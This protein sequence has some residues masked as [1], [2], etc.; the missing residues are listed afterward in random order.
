MRKI[1]CVLVLFKKNNHAHC[2]TELSRPCYTRHFFQSTFSRN[3]RDIGKTGLYFCLEMRR[4]FLQYWRYC[5]EKDNLILLR[6]V[7]WALN[8]KKVARHWVI[9][10]AIVSCNKTLRQIERVKGHLDRLNTDWMS[11]VSQHLWEKS[12]KIYFNKLKRMITK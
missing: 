4:I 5:C 2:K 7:Q 12:R 3:T 6:F 10:H 1:T 11:S 9:A 8:N